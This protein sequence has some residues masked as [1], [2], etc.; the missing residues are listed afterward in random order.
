MKKYIINY[1]TSL[2]M[3]TALLGSVLN[4]FGQDK[5]HEFSIAVGGPSSFLDYKTSGQLVEGNGFSAGLR[6]AYY[7]SENLSIGIGAE[8]QSYN[9]D[10]KFQTISGRYAATDSEKESFQFR[11]RAT[12]LREEQKLGY[13][14]VPLHIQFETPGTTKLYVAAGAK[15][16]FAINGSYESTIQNL[17]TSG[18]YPQYNVEL[19]GPA[20]AG[21]GSTNNV[22][23]GKQD[24]NAEVSYSV[25]F[26]TGVKQ[27]IGDKSSIYLGAYLDYGLNNVYDRNTSKHL[28]QYNPG[29]TAQLE[30]NTVL[31]SP[32]TN[33]VRL[34]SLGLKLRFAIR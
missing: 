23:V 14:N 8:Y 12:N 6:Y 1:I 7:L 21:F 24:L 5:K 33:D 29:T 26:E 32:F 31:D 9:T 17:T 22:K 20:F 34:V 28:V 27:I 18:Y 19:F 3:I 30:H 4:S 13:I 25:T 10:A 15:I 11:F 16:G 2:S